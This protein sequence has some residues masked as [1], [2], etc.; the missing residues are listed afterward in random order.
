MRRAAQ[1]GL[2]TFPVG[3]VDVT[4]KRVAATT[5]FCQVRK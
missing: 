5:A 4:Q 3:S 2:L 1:L